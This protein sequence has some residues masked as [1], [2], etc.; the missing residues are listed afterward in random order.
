MPRQ[1]F[2]R[3]TV[4]HSAVGLVLL[5]ACADAST[6]GLPT[7]DP[8]AAPARNVVP[9]PT[10]SPT[11]AGPTGQVGSGS[12]PTASPGGSAGGLVTPKPGTGTTFPTPAPTP[13]PSPRPTFAP[14][15]T[16]AP[17]TIPVA[18]VLVTAITVSALGKTEP[19]AEPAT[20]SVDPGTGNEP[21]QQGWELD[22]EP[23]VV[24]TDPGKVT[25]DLTVV[26]NDTSIVTVVEQSKPLPFGG[27]TKFWRL[28][29]KKPGK[30]TLVMTSLDPSETVGAVNKFLTR[31]FAI[32]V[33]GEGRVTVEVR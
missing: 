5:A 30:T 25:K 7:V 32:E 26:S 19:L 10:P 11:P 14:S 15:P 4:R 28:T 29:G 23:K 17:T 22:I 9:R 6:T 12:A 27:A 8:T 20:L 3:R 2:L 24:Y 18:P 1:S 33:S 31:T 21:L 13:T 16:V